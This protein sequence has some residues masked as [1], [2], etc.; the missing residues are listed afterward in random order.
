LR[1]Y[2]TQEY[3]NLAY[4]NVAYQNLAYQSV[5]YQNTKGVL[6]EPALAESLLA[7][8]SL[9]ESLLAEPCVAEP[10][11]LDDGWNRQTDWVLEREDNN[12][13]LR[14]LDDLFIE[15]VG[16]LEADTLLSLS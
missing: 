15:H 3:Q 7:E 14:Q 4:Q 13:D 2:E 16:H 5:V 9:A 10:L 6:A 1:A 12:L 8:P 11:T